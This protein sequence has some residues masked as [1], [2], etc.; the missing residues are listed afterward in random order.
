MRF[1]FLIFFLI[2]LPG[3]GNSQLA[4]DIVYPSQNVALT[5]SDSIVVYGT[6]NPPAAQVSIN[7]Y[8]VRTHN[9]GG[10]LARVPTPSDDLLTCLAVMKGDS[11]RV[12]R[13]LP[14]S[15]PFLSGNGSLFDTTFVFPKHDVVL[16]PGEVLEVA[17]RGAANL[18]AFFSVAGLIEKRSMI[19]LASK[20]EVVRLKQAFALTHPLAAPR[21]PGI[22]YGFYQIP[23]DT[24]VQRATVTFGVNGTNGQNIVLAAAGTVSVMEEPHQV[25]ELT[26]DVFAAPGHADSIPQ[27][28]LPAGSQVMTN[29][30]KNGRLRA[31]LADIEEAWLP[32]DKVRFIAQGPPLPAAEVSEIK[33]TALPSKLRITVAL[34][35]KVPYKV[36]QDTDPSKLTV[37]LL[38][39]YSSQRTTI[40]YDSDDELIREIQHQQPRRNVYRLNIH[41]NRAQQWGHD[42]FYAEEGLT[43]DIRKPPK[44]VKLKNMLICVD[45]GHAPDDGRLGPHRLKEKDA[46][47]RVAVRLKEALE[48]KG[49]VVYLTRTRRHGASAEVRRQM[50]AF[51]KADLFVSIH[52]AMCAHTSDGFFRRGTST[53]YFFPQSRALARAI[54]NRL[55]DELR[56]FDGGFYHHPALVNRIS[57]MP[58]VTVKPA[59]IAYPDEEKWLRSTEYQEKTAEAI[60]KGI[61]DF[62]KQAKKELD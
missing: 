50:A 13:S 59:A 33:M 43:I 31:R 15:A 4:L 48:K 9:N 44:D 54:Q 36:E 34:D 29:G 45:P 20:E 37:T 24:R 2:V 23:D 5:P 62:L 7:G 47:L 8:P 52:H 28:V 21:P 25:V 61:E 49:A 56:L 22:Y 51:L 26:E 3:S 53:S 14:I 1:P 19:E 30:L 41:L 12:R 60:V 11:V 17:F 55:R 32:G 39:A 57:Q 18:D 46:N 42:L 6:V 35:N 16:Q 58:A 38:N 40:R 27:I 10:F